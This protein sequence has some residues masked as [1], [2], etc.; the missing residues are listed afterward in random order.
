MKEYGIFN[1]D[2]ADWTE[3]ESL[4]SGFYSLESAQEAI[5][6]RY[7]AEDEVTVHAIEEPDD[8]EEDD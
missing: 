3:A 1:D 2:S 8:D 6:V 4:E 7:S 5:K